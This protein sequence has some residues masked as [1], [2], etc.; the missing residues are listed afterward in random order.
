MSA[1][2]P[3]RAIPLTAQY[4]HQAQYLLP[5]RSDLQAGSR[6]LRRELL[7]LSEALPVHLIPSRTETRLAIALL[8]SMGEL[9]PWIQV[10]DPRA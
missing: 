1:P 9:A 7:L 3:L 10:G 5:R 6:A 2:T 8:A 4:L